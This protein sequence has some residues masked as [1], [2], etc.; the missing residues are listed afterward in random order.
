MKERAHSFAVIY[1][2]TSELN[3]LMV[4]FQFCDPF[5]QEKVL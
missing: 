3:G 1:V 2:K 5:Y 4:E